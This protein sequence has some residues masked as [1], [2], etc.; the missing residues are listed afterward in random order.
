MTGVC[1]PALMGPR[2]AEVDNL[3]LSWQPWE[4][5]RV[6]VGCDPIGSVARL[7]PGT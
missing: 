7:Q 2:D 4:A 6:T 1:D 3:V 5:D